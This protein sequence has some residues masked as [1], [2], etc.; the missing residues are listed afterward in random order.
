MHI[1]IVKW[2]RW[3]HVCPHPHSTL[4]VCP[5]SSSLCAG[6]ATIE[7]IRI[8]KND[9]QFIVWLASQA[10]V[11]NGF[12]FGALNCKDVLL[13][14][15]SISVNPVSLGLLHRCTLGL[16]CSCHLGVWTIVVDTLSSIKRPQHKEGIKEKSDSDHKFHTILKAKKSQWHG[17]HL[18]QF[19]LRLI[20]SYKENVLFA[21]TCLFGL[22]STWP[23]LHIKVC[24]GEYSSICGHMRPV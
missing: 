13:P 11:R 12:W 9:H 3:M 8:F 24:F 5:V 20:L 18:W 16:I 15:G 17:N 2:L 23:L 22:R 7:I 4:Q 14:S 6:I 10:N 19:G 21:A 1:Y